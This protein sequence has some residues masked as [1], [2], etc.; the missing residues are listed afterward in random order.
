MTKQSLRFLTAFGMT[1]RLRLLHG[2]YTE[3]FGFLS[4][5][6]VNVFAMTIET[7]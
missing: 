4:T 7:P 6:S 2:V 1:P 5:G 3:Y